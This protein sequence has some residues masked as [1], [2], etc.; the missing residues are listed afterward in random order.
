[1]ISIDL[2]WAKVN[3]GQELCDKIIQEW[4]SG[5]KEWATYYATYL[6]DILGA[7]STESE[8]A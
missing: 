5:A 2:N 1:M 3:E 7:V 6:D 4:M 8:S